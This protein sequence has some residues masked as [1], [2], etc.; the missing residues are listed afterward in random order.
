[1]LLNY[2]ML[3]LYGSADDSIALRAIAR[4][5]GAYTIYI[6]CRNAL[7]TFVNGRKLHP[8]H[9]TVIHS[10]TILSIGGC[11]PSFPGT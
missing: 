9:L 4:D 1:M 3:K 11:Y 10:G 6:E 8:G 5:E 2:S 7:G